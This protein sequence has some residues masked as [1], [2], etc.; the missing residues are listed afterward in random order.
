MTQ[1]IFTDTNFETGESKSVTIIRTAC[2]ACRREIRYVPP[3]NAAMIDY[4]KLAEHYRMENH[5]LRRCLI[6]L[7]RRFNLRP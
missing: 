1:E 4:R 2:P 7:Q 6:D 5:T 3:E